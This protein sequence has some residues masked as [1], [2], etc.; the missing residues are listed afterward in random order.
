MGYNLAKPFLRAQLEED[1]KRCMWLYELPCVLIGVCE[2]RDCLT[3]LC[4]SVFC[5]I[6]RICEGVTTKDGKSMGVCRRVHLVVGF[7]HTS[8]WETHCFVMHYPL[9]YW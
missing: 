7:L 1:L 3:L 2:S 4:V 9:V 8:V 6:H 5:C